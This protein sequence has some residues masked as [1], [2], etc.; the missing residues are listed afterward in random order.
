MGALQ[1]KRIAENPPAALDSSGMFMRGVG[2]RG[3][4][5]LRGRCISVVALRTRGPTPMAEGPTTWRPEGASNDACD[6]AAPPRRRLGPPGR[7]P[8]RPRRGTRPGPGRD[9]GLRPESPRSVGPRR[10]AESPSHL[11]PRARQRHRRPRR[12]D[13]PRGRPDVA[14][15]GRGAARA[16]RASAA[17]TTSARATA[18]SGRTRPGATASAS[19]CRRPTSSPSP[20]ASA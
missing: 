5:E 15:P 9:R 7:D 13:R 12:R 16:S 6:H 3:K 10:A 18:S 2:R 14:G 17:G 11:P 8:A 20:R 4:G 1:R 19:A